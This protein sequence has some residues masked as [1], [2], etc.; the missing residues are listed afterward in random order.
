MT[1]EGEIQRLDDRLE[2]ILRSRHSQIML[3]RLH[4]MDEFSGVRIGKLPL[5]VITTDKKVFSATMTPWKGTK[6]DYQLMPL[7]ARPK[8]AANDTLLLR[9]KGDFALAIAQVK[10]TTVIGANFVVTGFDPRRE[11]RYKTR[12]TANLRP[13]SDHCMCELQSKNLTIVRANKP[14]DSFFE[15]LNNKNP[16]I[17][18][19]FS[20]DG[21]MPCSD[22][23]SFGTN[24]A[25]RTLIIDLSDQGFAALAQVSPQFDNVRQ[26]I[27]VCLEIKLPHIVNDF[28][29]RLMAVVR[30]IRPWK[31]NVKSIHCSFIEQI[32]T[33]YITF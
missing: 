29:L 17:T 14:P 11:V 6:A 19:F 26:N 9:M 30:D 20:K 18:D 13:V 32:P 12:M 10:V 25:F 28:S 8:I 22:I 23:E 2:K 33:S 27:F 31:D 16:V 7:E 3:S 21:I 24:E 5:Q 15:A 1:K 4:K